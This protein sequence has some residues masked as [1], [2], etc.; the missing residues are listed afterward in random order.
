MRDD[1]EKRKK[2]EYREELRRQM[3]EAYANKQRLTRKLLCSRLSSSTVC[4][5]YFFDV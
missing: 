5:Q 2:A 4:Q 1:E 3:A